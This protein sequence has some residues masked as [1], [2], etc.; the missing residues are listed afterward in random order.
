MFRQCSPRIVKKQTAARM[1]FGI[2]IDGHSPIVQVGCVAGLL[3]G[4][5]VT[6]CLAVVVSCGTKYV[7]RR[8]LGQRYHRFGA[9][10][11]GSYP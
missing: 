11:H 7:H 2:P 8:S 5:D 4:A 10:K 1:A 3:V 6:L 9:D